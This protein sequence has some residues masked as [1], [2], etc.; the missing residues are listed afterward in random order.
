MNLSTARSASRAKEIGIRKVIGGNRKNIITQFLF[1]SFTLTIIAL[2]LAILLVILF[3]GVFNVTSGK[4]IS[5]N[6][7]FKPEFIIGVVIV[8]IVTGFLAGSYPALFLSSFQPIKVLKGKLSS[9]AKRS[10]LRKILVVI[11]FTLSI[12]LIAGTII[13]YNQ[14]NFMRNKELG[15]N[16]DHLLYIPMRGGIKNSYK[17]IKNEFLKDPRI[18][19]VTSTS[20]PPTYIGSNSGGADWDGKDPELRTLISM[21]GVDFDYIKTLQIEM[22]EGRAFSEE[23]AADVGTD[24]TG[25]FLVNEEVVKIM[26]VDNPVGMRFSFIGQTGNIVGVMKNFHYQPVSS[27]IEPLAIFL[28]PMKYLSY[29]LVRV[30]SDKVIQSMEY[31]EDTWADLMPGHPFDY[32]FLDEDFDT[33]YRTESRMGTLLKYFAIIAIFIASLGLFGLTSFTA[34]Q[35]TKEIGIRK[36]MGASVPKVVYLLSSEFLGLVIV[37]MIFSIP[38]SVYFMSQWLEDY[39][40]RTPLSWWIFALASTLV[41]V[42]AI[43]TVSYQAIKTGLTNP[44]EALR[45][46]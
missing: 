9:G 21:S 4:E 11:Q 20:H 3:I 32:S 8:T 22:K 39:A 34:E 37:S 17:A 2:I 28:S 27:K 45:Y 30:Q 42:I 24:S 41:I 15:Y 43:L 19:S 35:R 31:L 46:E 33:M 1:E 44:A 38:T 40:Y 36:T 12:F 26:D 16:K 25:N 29:I 18:L 14:L 10:Y 13:V 5:A 23:F 6:V 7:L